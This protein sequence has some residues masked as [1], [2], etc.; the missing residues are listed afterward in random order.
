VVGSVGATVGG[1]S[2]DRLISAFGLRRGPQILS[3][4]SLV[5]CAVFLFL[6]ATSSD[7][8]LAV[9]LLCLAFGFTQITEAPYWSTM[10]SVASRDAS[11]AGGVLNTGGNAVGFVGGMLVPLTAKYFGWVV[12]VSMGS[13]FALIAASLW[14]FIRGDRPML[15]PKKSA[16]E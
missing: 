6:G 12:A 8:L 16:M 9:V 5:L 7:P 3:I 14:L 4:A 15:E 2:C 11:E 1:L 10:I 13:I